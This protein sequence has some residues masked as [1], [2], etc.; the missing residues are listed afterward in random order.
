MAK[1][2]VTTQKANIPGLKSS[3][4]FNDFSITWDNGSSDSSS[5]FIAE[6]KATFKVTVE[7]AGLNRDDKEDVMR[8]VNAISLGN[9]DNFKEQGWITWKPL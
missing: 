9:I 4:V 3:T 7:A 5:Q 2:L 1:Y 8:E 6:L